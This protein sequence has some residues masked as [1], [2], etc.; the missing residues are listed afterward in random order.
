M[1]GMDSER[2]SRIFPLSVQIEDDNDLDVKIVFIE[3]QKSRFNPFAG[4]ATFLLPTV[5]SQNEIFI[6]S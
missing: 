4:R 5:P 3:Q 2:E 6:V 1:I